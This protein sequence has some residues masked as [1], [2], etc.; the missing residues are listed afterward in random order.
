M[1]WDS[2]DLNRA[3]LKDSLSSFDKTIC[4]KQILKTV[5]FG[6]HAWR[7]GKSMARYSCPKLRGPRLS[8]I[9]LNLAARIQMET[10]H[11]A[12]NIKD[13]PRICPDRLSRDCDG[14]CFLLG[15]IA[16]DHLKPQPNIPCLV[17][18]GDG[19]QAK[20]RLWSAW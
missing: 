8:K 11:E 7:E 4:Q 1:D 12:K 15:R 9:S 6:P 10:G 5:L 17:S 14:H 2:M 16:F 3:S 19:K 13:R 20:E 18:V